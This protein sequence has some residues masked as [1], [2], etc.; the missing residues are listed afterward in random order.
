MSRVFDAL[1]KSEEEIGK[2]PFDS[3]ETFF[4]SIE[5]KRELLS[6]IKVRIH[7]QPEHRIVVYLE[8]HSPASERFRLL[9]T[10][11]RD[12]QSAGKPKVLLVTSALPG[13]GKTTVATNLA[14]VLAEQG[15]CRVLLLE[16]DLRHPSLMRRW[17]LKPWDGL[18]ECLQNDSDP[19]SFTRFVEPLGIHVLPAGNHAANPIELLRFERYSRLIQSLVSKFDWLIVDCPPAI[20]VADALTLKGAADATLL[21]MR[22]GHTPRQAVEDTIKKFGLGHVIGI[23]LNSAEGAGDL[24]SDYYRQ[25]APRSA[26]HTFESDH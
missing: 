25:A 3:P 17:G 2:H 16:A 13:D 12:L 24:Y 22:A 26:H 7:V 15:G 20:P 19:C 14:T 21:V 6:A 10:Y 9:R 8:P 4:D 11:L 18:A 5:K 23:I 1:R